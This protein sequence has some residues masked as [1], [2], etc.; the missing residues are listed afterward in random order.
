MVGN[1]FSCDDGALMKK[2]SERQ[3]SFRLVL[4]MLT[5]FWVAGCGTLEVGLEP[6]SSAGGP[7][8][9]TLAALE[10]ERNLLATQVAT[11]QAPASLE[12]LASWEHLDS[13]LIAEEQ[14]FALSI[15]LRE[16]LVLDLSEPTVPREIGRSDPLDSD[17]LKIFSPGIDTVYAQTAEEL[18]IISAA[19]PTKPEVVGTL[20]FPFSGGHALS[21]GLLHIAGP[22]GMHVLDVS[23]PTRPEEV[24]TYRVPGGANQMFIE[25]DVAYAT[26]AEFGLRIINLETLEAAYEVG[27]FVAG[28]E[29]FEGIFVVEDVAYA[30][31]INGLV[32]LD[33][34]DPTAPVALDRYPAPFA[35]SVVV[36]GTRAYLSS[37]RGIHVLDVSDPLNLRLVAA[38]EDPFG[39]GPV[40]VAGEVLYES[41]RFVRVYRLAP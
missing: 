35:G 37:D 11:M 10:A 23:D 20:P 32:V 30:T 22:M 38:Y 5:A 27:A 2:L 17:V 24:A 8:S 41:G 26:A 9:A 18:F 36:E 25:G 15:G 34:A 12:L 40:T 14:A 28:R 3:R 29:W 4:F 39:F 7:V 1:S 31:T 21:N 19:D 16:L 33:V 6:D 13:I